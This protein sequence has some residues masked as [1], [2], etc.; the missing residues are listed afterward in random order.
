[1][2][3]D[4]K[5]DVLKYLA[6]SGEI[7]EIVGLDIGKSVIEYVKQGPYFVM[8]RSEIAFDEGES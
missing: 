6:E 4:A 7:E 2:G 3:M 8:P 5:Y 1:M